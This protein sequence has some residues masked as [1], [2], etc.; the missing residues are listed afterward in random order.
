MGWEPEGVHLAM[1]A[2][3]SVLV[4]WQTGEPRT[5]PT[6]MPPA[7]HD[8]AE[9]AG[10]VRLGT[11]SG[12]YNQT[13]KDG[14]NGVYSYVYGEAAGGTTYRSPILHHVLLTGL[15]PG[16]TY[17]YAVGEAAWSCALLRRTRHLPADAAVKAGRRLSMAGMAAATHPC[18]C[19]RAAP[20]WH[21]HP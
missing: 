11:E 17:F 15:Q 21:R 1:W 19:R 13:F 7:P 5:G 6:A 3:D 18:A 9:V 8:R 4:S 10:L 2:R 12:R 14:T 16:Q 20:Q